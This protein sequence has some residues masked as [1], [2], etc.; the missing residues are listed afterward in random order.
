MNKR[1]RDLLAQMKEKQAQADEH[2]KK[3]ES[4]EFNRLIAEIAD[5]QAAYNTEKSVYELEKSGVPEEKQAVGS[6]P[7]GFTLMAKVIK[8]KP[9]T[10]AENAMLVGDEDTG[11]NYLV[12]EDVSLT[13]R[14]A[15]KSY[16]SVAL[17]ELVRVYPTSMLSGSR[18]YDVEGNGKLIAFEDGDEIGNLPEPNFVQKKWSVNQYGGF[19]AVSNLLAG[20]E[21]AGLMAYINNEFVRDAI[22]TENEIILNA[23]KRDKTPIEIKGLAGLKEQINLGIEPDYLSDGVI[24]T[25]QTGWH[26]LDSETDAVG[27]PMLNRDPLN[28]TQHLYMGL[29]VVRLSDNVLENVGGKAPVFIGSLKAGICFFDYTALEF[30]VSKEVEFRRNQTVIRVIERFAVEQEFPQAYIYGL[31]SA[32]GGKV[33]KTKA[34]AATA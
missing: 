31:L 2:L 21:K 17:K 7:D 19:M 22:R 26:M 11:T 14:E 15:R 16:T 30:A 24:V 1:M 10:D 18:V 23:L 9:L 13:I 6:K 33:V 28:P 20:A 25:N 5:L 12:P 3:G 29:R 34:E 27:R 32:D 8:R 4:G